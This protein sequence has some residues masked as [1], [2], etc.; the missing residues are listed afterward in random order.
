MTTALPAACKKIDQPA[1]ALVADLKARG[2]WTQRWFTGEAKWGV[3]R[4]FKTKKCR[5]RP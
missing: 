2:L 1:A 3:C 4:S 5:P